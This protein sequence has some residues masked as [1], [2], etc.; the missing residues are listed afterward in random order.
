MRIYH[1]VPTIAEDLVNKIAHDAITTKDGK[2]VLVEK[3]S[4]IT[5]AQAKKVAK[6]YGG[7][8][9]RVKAY[10]RQDDM[11]FISPEYDEKTYIAD[12]TTPIDEY[13]NILHD[14][15]P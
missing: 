2:T 15:V 3:G 14:R 9:I 4:Y 13:N 5:E 7:E 8:A 1:T 10:F 11:E 12:V 6:E